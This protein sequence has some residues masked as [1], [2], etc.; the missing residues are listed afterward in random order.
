MHLRTKRKNC[1]NS[2][3]ISYMK[4]AFTL[5]TIVTLALS[6]TACGK[7]KVKKERPPYITPS[8][9]P[10]D[11]QVQ[12]NIASYAVVPITKEQYPKTYATWG[13]DGVRYLN[14]LTH[15]VAEEAVKH[16]GGCGYVHMVELQAD[17]AKS[18]KPIFNVTCSFTPSG[19]K[20]ERYIVPTAAI[21][22][23]GIP[24]LDGSKSSCISDK[25]FLSAC[26]D[27]AKSQSTSPDSFTTD[28][29]YNKVFRTIDGEDITVT[30]PFKINYGEKHIAFCSFKKDGKLVKTNI[31]KDD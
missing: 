3:S 10:S 22:T 24:N 25:E 23:S 31:E 21:D 26:I 13:K 17:Q 5:L 1:K 8:Y 7:K 29:T 2:T 27:S 11:E 6:V 4:K 9:Q 19:K 15:R 12:S 28:M 14:S 18:N 16:W 20:W 30:L